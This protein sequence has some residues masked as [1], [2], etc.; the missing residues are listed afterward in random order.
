ME[1]CPACN[2]AA[3]SSVRRYVFL[4]SANTDR[5]RCSHCRTWLQFVPPPI[6]R[7][8]VSRWLTGLNLNLVLFVLY[9]LLLVGGL[10]A[11]VLVAVQLPTD[12]LLALF[13]LGLSSA[14]LVV[15]VRGIRRW[16]RATLVVAMRQSSLP[17]L[18]LL[19]DIRAAWSDTEFRVL[20]R[21]FALLLLELAVVGSL[22]AYIFHAQRTAA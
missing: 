5:F 10:S 9:P 4:G 14:V 22:A 1:A 21:R 8:P 12:L 17:S 15:S 16:S 7:G 2:E 18:D 3:V 20:V 13:G 11:L 19:R 6:Q